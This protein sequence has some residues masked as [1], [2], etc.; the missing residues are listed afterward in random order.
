LFIG[1][2]VIGEGI[3]STVKADMF[4]PGCPPSPDRILRALLSALGR[5]PNAQK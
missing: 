2:R 3:G 4:I 1:G 5:R